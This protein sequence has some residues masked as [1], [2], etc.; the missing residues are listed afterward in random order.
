M[1][2]TIQPATENEK[3]LIPDDIEIKDPNV[4]AEVSQ[5]EEMVDKVLGT[6]EYAPA[7]NNEEEDE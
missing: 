4:Q 6:S 2:N 1:A 5:V 7:E 3:S